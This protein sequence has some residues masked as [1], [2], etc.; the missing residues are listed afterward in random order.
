MKEKAKYV[1]LFE[2]IKR[3]ILQGIYQNGQRLPGENELAE[4]FGL[5]RQTVRQ[6][7]SMLE[8]GG[9]IHRRQ[10]SGTYVRRVE[11]RRERS[12]NVGVIATYISEY[13]FPSILRGIESELSEEGFFPL[14]SATKNRVDNERRILEEYMEKRVDGLIVEGTKSALPNPNLPLYEK[15]SEMGIPV[16]FFNNYYPALP[17]CVSVKMDDRQ[18]G[19]AAVEYLAARGHRRI[20]GIF[21][22]DDMQGLG[23]YDGYTRG[24]LQNGILLQDQ[25]VTWFDSETRESLFSDESTLNRLLEKLED[26]T[27]VVCYNDTIA[28]KL[29]KALL[30][31][32]LRV[33][34]DKAVISFDNSQLGE[35]AAVGLTTFDHPKETL[36][37]CA[38]RKLIAMMNGREESSALMEW[39]L[40][41][42]E[43]V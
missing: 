20:A 2:E 38:A 31:R 3:R 34:Q 25:W 35:L 24:L 21:K 37:A 39:G 29:E 27:A 14:V 42:R 22:G 30:S 16:V 13:I 10:G 4:E 12:W 26:C 1:Q 15:L 11:Q 17:G 23:R 41:E 18:G 32:G 28:V 19:V 36:G 33:P 8:Q 5:S 9:F 6:A 40:V 7:L 43:S